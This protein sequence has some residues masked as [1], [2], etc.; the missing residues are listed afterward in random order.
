MAVSLDHRVVLIGAA[1][2]L[3]VLVPLILLYLA[4]GG[5]TIV[6]PIAGALVAPFAGGLVA[7]RQ[8]TDAPLTHGAAAAGLASVGYI[9]FRLVDAVARNNP[10]HPASVAFLVIVAI[11]CGLLGAW[12]GFRTRPP[13]E[14]A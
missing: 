8:P 12:V 6:A 3:L 13:V 9:A 14:S 11:T 7:G 4:L 5:A 2:D 1:V 10:V